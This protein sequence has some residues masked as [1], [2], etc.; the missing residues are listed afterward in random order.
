MKGKEF[1]SKFS[2]HAKLF[3]SSVLITL[4]VTIIVSIIFYSFVTDSLIREQVGFDLFS[5]KKAGESFHTVHQNLESDLQEL[6]RSKEIKEILGTYFYE[7]DI[8]E[9]ERN[10]KVLNDK[11]TKI[12]LTND[13]LDHIIIVGENGLA[14]SSSKENGGRY[15]GKI[16]DFNVFYQKALKSFNNE[17]EANPVY[18]CELHPGG[19]NDP[20]TTEIYNIIKNKLIIFRSLK[21]ENG[22]TY[23]FVIF[24]FRL[25]FLF[26]FFPAGQ[27]HSDIFLI[28][29]KKNIIWTNNYAPISNV[30]PEQLELNQKTFIV[31]KIGNDRVII[32]QS[33]LLHYPYKLI[34]IVKLSHVF[35]GIEN[36]KLYVWYFE[37][38]CFLYALVISYYYARKISNPLR[39]L[40]KRL[41]TFKNRDKEYEEIPRSKGRLHKKLILFFSLSTLLPSILFI[42]FTFNIYY[43]SYRDEIIG[44]S[45]DSL[46]ITKYSIDFEFDILKEKLKNFLFNKAIQD[47]L[48]NANRRS[49]YED[50]VLRLNEM[51]QDIR[52][53]NLEYINLSLF[54][55]SGELIYSTQYFDS[56]NFG[57]IDEKFLKRIEESNGE[58]VFLGITEDYY[59]IPQF[60]FARKV[61][62]IGSSLNPCIG[63][64]KIDIALEFIKNKVEVDAQKW[65]DYFIINDNTSRMITLNN[66]MLLDNINSKGKEILERSG[67]SSDNLLIFS[68]SNEK[69]YI[70]YLKSSFYDITYYSVVSKESINKILSPLKWYILIT[71]LVAV[72]ALL[73]ASFTVSLSIIVPFKRLLYFVKKG[74]RNKN[75]N[76]VLKIR[77]ND[78]IAVL[79]RQFNNMIDEINKLVHEI[80][81]SKLRE[82]ELLFLHKEAQYN[83][84]QQQINPHFLYN[85]LDSINWMAYKAGNKDVCKA[86]SALAKYFKGVIQN[87]DVISVENE[88]K[89]LENY[90][91][92]LKIRH[93]K[94]I[95]FYMDIAD[96]IKEYKTI[97][98]LLQPFI[99]NAVTHG[100]EG[101]DRMGEVTIKG[102]MHEEMICFAVTDNGR[103]MSDL[104]LKGLL[105]KLNTQK[106]NKEHIGIQN[107]YNRLRLYFGEQAKISIESA[108]GE[109]TTV[110]IMHPKE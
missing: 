86:I 97:K 83:A 53:T 21:N 65:F 24:T 49:L 103:G 110:Y 40:Q 99:E 105:E 1:F 38:F 26:S 109:G 84:L 98:L 25:D 56:R 96:D 78:E 85:T 72:A 63:Y 41:S 36:A 57:T 35:K 44:H 81:L 79:S 13:F 30:S 22:Q 27:T 71:I 47:I 90:I 8:N 16:R 17:T 74:I 42:F 43:G 32:I 29:D 59:S 3:I 80:Y 92:I 91:Y 101:L 82:K 4:L 104:K 62:Y 28:D 93:Y 70:P 31:K 18:F 37:I 52:A 45:F 102:Y 64:A 2:L 60:T 67:K 19:L 46:D 94:K 68:G 51:V 87:P 107:V 9:I 23:G 106:D 48:N 33:D 95:D 54:I 12:F 75:Y 69:Y 20:I 11:S 73:G 100:L 14:Y 50:E 61:Y 5:F 108:E 34:K 6:N 39:W 66:H 77:G 15:Q 7:A 10:I 89:H 55:K 58:I 88:I 76:I